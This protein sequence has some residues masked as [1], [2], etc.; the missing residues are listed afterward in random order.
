MHLQKDLKLS[1]NM[2]DQL[3]QPLPLTATS[4]EVYK[5]AKL[6]INSPK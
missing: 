6:P 3:E 1:L 5:H 2:A 4:N